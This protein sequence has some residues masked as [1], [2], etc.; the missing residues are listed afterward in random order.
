MPARARRQ[1]EAPA[2][3]RHSGESG[4]ALMLVFLMAAVIAISLY[5]EIPRVAFQSQRH[6]EQLLME[7]GEQYKRAIQVYFATNRRYPQTMDD[8]EKSVTRHFLRH[9]YIDPMTGK[10]EWRIIHIQG[11]V[12]VDSLLNKN[13]GLQQQQQQTTGE[14]PYIT[15]NAGIGQSPGGAQVRPQDRRR[16]SEG[17]APSG[18]GG[19]YPGMPGVGMAP[20]DGTNPDG[21][22]QAG[23]Q[24]QPGMPGNQMQ[25]SPGT[26][27]PP[28]YP[29]APGM[30]GMPQGVAGGQSAASSQNQDGGYVTALPGIGATS[31]P[32]SAQMNPVQPNPN[33]PG[34]PNMQGYPNMPGGQP[35]QPGLPTAPNGTPNSATQMISDILTRPNPAGY[36]AALRAQGMQ[37]PQVGGSPGMTGPGVAGATVG[38]G[39]MAG[40]G[41]GI[42]GIASAAKLEGI[43]VYND[44]T[45]YNEWE[46]IFDP[47]KVPRIP[48]P[49][50]SGAGGVPASRIGTPASQMSQTTGSAGGGSVGGAFGGG[51]VQGA[52]NMPGGAGGMQIGGPAG[53]QSGQMNSPAGM[54]TGQMSGAAG[55]QMGLAGTG[56]TGLP[57]NIRLGRP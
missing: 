11:G 13:P 22:Q 5:R 40:G 38:S 4:Y 17:G 51:G 34:Y 2:L 57:A 47:A 46:F 50:G 3:R 35:G 20:A 36:A 7:R 18:M 8:L 42:A 15:A 16:A 39:V 44:R 56:N 55:M 53:M 48:P 21:Q 19:D 43:M 37:P 27:V 9:H 31:T 52:F 29:G 49:P 25:G 14:G 41:D 54:Q 24:P 26:N 6:K 30:P 10:S 12:L 33:M 28:G 32:Q 45:A 23:M 1:A